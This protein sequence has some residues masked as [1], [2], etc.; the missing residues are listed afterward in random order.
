MSTRI[1]AGSVT[2]APGAISAPVEGGS[3]TGRAR[4]VE[5]SSAGPGL[6]LG[7][8][9]PA[10]PRQAAGSTPW[11][12]ATIAA[13]SSLGRKVLWTKPSAPL[14][15]TADSSE[16]D[17]PHRE[18]ADRWK[19]GTETGDQ[20]DAAVDLGEARIDD[21]DIGPMVDGQVERGADLASTGDDQALAADGE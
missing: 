5:S 17:Q 18:D 10:P 21:H 14:S 16:S 2:S 12:A 8:R 20:R 4:A 3:W 11:V 7:V 1:G 6:D 13:V 9:A 15:R 19:T